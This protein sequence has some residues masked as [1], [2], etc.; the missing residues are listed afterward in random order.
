[1][2]ENGH[3]GN[4]VDFRF[5]QDVVFQIHLHGLQTFPVVEFTTQIL[6]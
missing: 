5:K 2:V 1:M 6:A 4:T 3:F